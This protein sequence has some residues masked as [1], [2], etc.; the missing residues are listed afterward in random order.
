MVIIIDVDDRN[1]RNVAPPPTSRSDSR[2]GFI[3][4]LYLTCFSNTYEAKTSLVY[5]KFW[6]TKIEHF[7]STS[8]HL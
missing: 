8:I 4:Y 7:D 2:P 5:P 6:R 1:D 3:L